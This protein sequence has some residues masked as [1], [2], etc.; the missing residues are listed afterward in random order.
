M[1]DVI[2]IPDLNFPTLSYGDLETPLSLRSLL[3]Q[4][5]ARIR[6]NEIA[7]LIASGEL[8]NPR[9]ER[10][11]LVRRIHEE[12]NG[13]LVGGG[14]RSTLESAI[15]TFRALFTWAEDSHQ[16][17][18]LGRILATYLNW[19]DWLLHRVQVARDIQEN[20]AYSQ[21]A[22]VGTVLDLVLQRSTPIIELTRLWKPQ[23]RKSAVSPQ[24]EKQNLEGTFTFGHLLQDICDGLP[25]D[26]VL[27]SP[28]PIRVSIRNNEDLLLWAKRREKS[29][30]DI[31]PDSHFCTLKA[32]R[33]ANRVAKRRTGWEA[34]RS[35]RTRY[36][37][38]NIR[39]EAELLMFIG[40]TG[41][42]LAQA[43]QQKLI[44]FT[45]VSHTNGYQVKDRKHRRGGEVL[46]EIYADYKPHF[47]RY[48]AWLRCPP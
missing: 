36:P 16:P 38:A 31:P 23:Q 46:F 43:H 32:R 21:A 10:L 25:V 34:D 33:N 30:I 17:L 39:I 1:R 11:D 45:Y 9:V 44:N 19:T 3:F 41:M 37:L 47:E 6:T 26:V 48:L 8:G 27:N 12:L 4:A 28:V 24:A 22:T 13:R 40:Q 20:S 2:R 29:Y 35:L 15:S 18:T 14:R 42:N 5:G 7:A